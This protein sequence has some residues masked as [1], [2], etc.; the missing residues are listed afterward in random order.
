MTN[1][2]VFDAGPRVRACCPVCGDVVRYYAPKPSAP[3]CP[4]CERRWAVPLAIKPSRALP[5]LPEI[6]RKICP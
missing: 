4:T 3:R 2:I 5:R 1:G 6:K